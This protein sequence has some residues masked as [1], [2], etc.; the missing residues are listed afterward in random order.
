MVENE[1]SG[2]ASR[3]RV[4]T[5][6][7]VLADG[8]VVV[9]GDR[10]VLVAPWEDARASAWAVHV[11]GLGATDETLVPG[12]I[13]LH[14]HGGGGASFP[15]APDVAT[16]AVAAREHLSAGTTSLVAS[17]VTASP[18]TLL[19]RTAVLADLADAGEIAGIHLEGPFLSAARCGAQDPDLMQA[20][21]AGLV[22]E[23][24][25]VARGH[26][27]TMTVAPEVP[28]VAGAGG[29]ADVLADV[30]ALPSFGHTDAAAGEMRAAIEESFDRLA[31]D[32]VRS[33]RPTVTHLFNGMRPVAHREAG[34]IPDCLA[35]AAKGRAVVELVAD[36]TH[37]HPAVVRD[38]FDMVGPGNVVLVTD[39]M[40]A[41]GMPDGS[42]RLG[43]LDVL[44][45]D[46]VARLTHGGAIA[47]GTAHLA[48]VLRVT[49]EGG[50]PLVDA[51]RAVTATPAEVL[52]RQDL[53]RLAAG[54]RADVLVLG[55]DL[56]VRRVARAGTWV[57]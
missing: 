19:E 16:A 37:V 55:P 57:A 50:V 23:V 12:L 42:Y 3:G 8:V 29:V 2:W 11:E 28:G 34:P 7:G 48:Q 47:G 45:V 15:D 52:G 22:R 31:A 40:A 54:A 14:C 27:V 25:R 13:D 10:I 17:L 49:V 56:S 4:V 36:G 43:S 5:D 6:E 20:P 53:G 35:A 18:E 26:L 38:V 9:E 44:V 41:A 32:G 46:G 39:A 21:D 51:V 30:G 33:R 1:L 24:A